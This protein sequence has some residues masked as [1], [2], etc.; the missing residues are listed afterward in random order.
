[1]SL[2]S[3]KWIKSNNKWVRR[4][5]VVILRGYK[6]VKITDKVFKI[7]AMVM[8]DGDR[9]IKKAAS[10]ILREI[11]KTMADAPW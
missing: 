4:F 10:W 2:L 3:E 7:L 8:E 1:M 9:D 6:K 11:T 5:G